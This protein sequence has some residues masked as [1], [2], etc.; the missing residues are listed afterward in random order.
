MTRSL[1]YLTAGAAVVMALA[2]VWC[3]LAGYPLDGCWAVRN[4]T[5]AQ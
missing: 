3:A 4:S 1:L 5:F 2:F